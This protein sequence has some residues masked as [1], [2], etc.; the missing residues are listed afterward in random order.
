MRRGY[1]SATGPINPSLSGFARVLRGRGSGE[2]KLAF[3]DQ[4]QVANVNKRVREISQDAD[5]IASE[6]EVQ[7]HERASGDAPV[8]ERNWNYAFTLSLGCDPL[9][10]ETHR[11]KSVPDK[12]E[13]HQ[14]TPVQAKES[15]FF[16]DPGDSDKCEC[17]HRQSTCLAFRLSLHKGEGRVRV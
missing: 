12:A 15:V 1:F 9:N 13:N 11:E 8:P 16:A 7:A 5:G 17:V 4:H 2:S 14:V 10:E 3:T 6:N